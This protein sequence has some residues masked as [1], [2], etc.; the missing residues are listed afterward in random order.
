MNFFYSNKKIEEKD[1]FKISSAI[2]RASL[3]IEK[4][5]LI[6]KDSNLLETTKWILASFYSS[7][8]AVVIPNDLPEIYEQQL[9][10]QLPKNSFLFS[11]EISLDLAAQ[12][13][14]TESKNINEIW[15]LIFSSGSS[16]IPR[17]T[18]LSGL[19]LRESALAHKNHLPLKNNI[20]LLSLP[21][22]HISGFSI[23]SRA[24]FL[25]SSVCIP[26]SLRTQDLADEIRSNECISA[27]LVPYN[28]S[29]LRTNYSNI[30]QNLDCILVGGASLSKTY[31]NELVNENW[32]IYRT[33]GATETCSQIATEKAP[34][35]GMIPLNHMKIKIQ[36]DHEICIS[37]PSLSRGYFQSGKFVPLTLDQSFFSIGDLGEIKNNELLVHGR[38]S[39]LIISGGLN[40]YPS[41]IESIAKDF[42]PVE[43]AVAIGLEDSTW[44]QVLALAVKFKPNSQSNLV[45][46]RDFFTQKI[47]KRKIPKKWY[48]LEEI[49]KTSSGKIR[50]IPTKHLLKNKLP[51]LE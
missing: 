34:L 47:D 28:L 30:K 50:R 42:D 25:N 48:Q 29:Q 51:N 18:A 46:L 27:S 20:W 45:E 35:G 21:L 32:P 19:A 16:G 24:F 14:K 15:A 43:E 8:V 38:K 33:Y 49:L 23:I 36:P 41:E 9:I 6:I 12:N 31:A 5:F 40:I 22:F 10:N 2:A 13:F 11:K 4:Q 7:L 1:I 26:K 39:D 17:A 44:G 3:N 37:S